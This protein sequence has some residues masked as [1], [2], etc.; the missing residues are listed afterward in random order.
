MMAPKQRLDFG[1]LSPISKED[2]ESDARRGFCNIGRKIR[3]RACI[4][5]EGDFS[6]AHQWEPQNKGQTNEVSEEKPKDCYTN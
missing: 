1:G 2:R 4:T 3:E 5:K 6:K